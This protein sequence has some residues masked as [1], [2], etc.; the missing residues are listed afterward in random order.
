MNKEN[1]LLYCLA[2]KM[3]SIKCHFK[4]T[5]LQEANIFE[6]SEKYSPLLILLRAVIYCVLKFQ[7]AEKLPTVIFNTKKVYIM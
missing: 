3:C 2:F 5:N 4:N 7:L 1:I 6:N